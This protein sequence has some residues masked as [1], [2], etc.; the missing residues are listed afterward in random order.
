MLQQTKG[1]WSAPLLLGESSVEGNE[2]RPEIEK[3]VGDALARCS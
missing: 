2:H 1:A 3:E